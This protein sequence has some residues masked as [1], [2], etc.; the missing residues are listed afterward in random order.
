MTERVFGRTNFRFPSVWLSLTVPESPS[1]GWVGALVEAVLLTGVPLDVSSSPG[2]WGGAM[3]GTDATLMRTGNREVSRATDAGHAANLVRAHL[4]E[5]L[6]AIGREH[7][8]FYFMRVDEALEEH[9]VAGALMAL[10]EAR[11]EG[12][13]RFIGLYAAGEPHAALAAWRFHDAFDAVMVP[14]P[15]NDRE[16]YDVLAPLAHDRRVGFLGCRAFGAGC[17][18]DDRAA[19]IAERTREHPLLVPVSTPEEASKALAAGAGR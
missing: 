3:R 18:P 17:P 2:L 6:C 14:T 13:L 5:T 16:P 9:Q 10:D 7:L 4:I 8:D 11:Q 12:H 1:D 19:V 15:R